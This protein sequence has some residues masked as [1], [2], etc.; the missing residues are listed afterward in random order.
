MVHC[1]EEYVQ[2]E[3]REEFLSTC[4]IFFRSCEECY[5][6]VDYDAAAYELLKASLMILKMND[7]K[8]CL[9]DS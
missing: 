7:A 9:K 5:A 6:I 1:I 4:C 2:I 3:P 8:E